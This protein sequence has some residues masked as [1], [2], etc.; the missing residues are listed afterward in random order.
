[1]SSR[2][3]L[4]SERYAWVTWITKLLAGETQ[5]LWS[6]W[7]KA[8]YQGH[9]KEPSTFEKGAWQLDH[10]ELMR[11][12]AAKLRDDEFGV[13][14]EGQNKFS[15]NGKLG[16]LG[17]KPDIVAG[18]DGY[19]W[20]I[21][22][23][24]GEPKASDSVQVK[25]YMWAIPKALPRYK[26]FIFDGKIA[27][28]SGHTTISSTEIDQKFIKQVGDLLKQ[29]FGD[30]PLPKIP[31]F[32]ECQFCEITAEDCLDRTTAISENTGEVDDF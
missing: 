28:R 25:I 8:H 10:T 20:I 29:V 3:V 27:Y 2:A 13:T 26:G 30:E 23:K 7:F 1:M 4:R 6:A 21:D 24:T 18:K 17:G 32:N 9:A 12:E 14:L 16:T 31:S 5:C 15:L 19:G 11:K 22:A